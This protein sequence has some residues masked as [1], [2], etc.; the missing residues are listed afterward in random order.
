MRKQAVWMRQVLAGLLTIS[1]IAGS[2]PVTA[3]ADTLSD[4]VETAGG[5]YSFALGY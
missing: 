2:V 3:L 4:I 1:M 5:G